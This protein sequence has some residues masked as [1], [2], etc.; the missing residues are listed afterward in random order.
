MIKY[1]NFKGK[2]FNSETEYKESMDKLLNQPLNSFEN[3]TDLQNFIDEFFKPPFSNT[4]RNGMV[5]IELDYCFNGCRITFYSSISDKDG[6]SMLKFSS[7]D[8]CINGDILLKDF[9]K[10]VRKLFKE[11]LNNWKEILKD[12][13]EKL[14]EKIEDEFYE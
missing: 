11:V 2:S 4:W 5:K 14:L 10:E 8:Y 7:K 9:K 6:N 1:V 12:G 3:R 13:N